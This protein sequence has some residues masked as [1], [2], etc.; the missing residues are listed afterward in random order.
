MVKYSIWINILHNLRLILKKRKIIMKFINLYK[1]QKY[2]KPALCITFVIS[3]LLVSIWTYFDRNIFEL[4]AMFA[5]EPLHPWQYFTSYFQHMFYGIGGYKFIFIHMSVNLSIIIIFGTLLEKMIGT[6]RLL[7]LSIIAGSAQQLL[8][9]LTHKNIRSY[10]AGASGI[11]YSYIPIA[12]YFIL[13]VANEN[14]EKL[15]KETLIYI[16]II[17]ICIV[18]IIVTIVAPFIGTTI[19]HILATIIG[20]IFLIANKKK[21]KQEFDEL[22]NYKNQSKYRL[23]KI[24]WILL[25]IP[26]ILLSI[27]IL[28]YIGIIKV[29]YNW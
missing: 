4:F 2:G 21:L 22:I 19:Y 3:I 20:I 8:F 16:Y 14:K 27:I 1:K 26:I 11:A 29:T 13:K 12:L 18:W 15:F 5:P 10:G 6:Y 7:I 9:I 23:Y 17:E 25:L 28:H 24:K